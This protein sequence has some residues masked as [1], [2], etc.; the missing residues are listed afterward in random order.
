MIITRTPLRMSFVGG[1]SDISDFYRQHG[2]AVLSST[3]DQYVYINVHK[4]FS[5]QVRLAYSKVEEEENFSRIEHPLVRGAAMLTGIK[6][7]LE[8]T[9][10]ADIPSKGSGLGSSSSFAVGLL[11]ALTAY[12]GSDISKRL[13]AEQACKLEIELCEQPIGKQD[14]FAASFGGFNI[15]KFAKNDKV[16]VEKLSVTDEARFTLHQHMMVFYTGKTRSASL[17]LADQKRAMAKDKTV[18]KMLEMVELV[19]TFKECLL[20]C[21]AKGSGE[22]LDINWQ[23]KKSLS[24]SISSSGIDEVYEIARKAGAYGG[25]LLGAGGSGFLLFLVPPAKQH[26]VSLALAKLQRVYW[27]FDTVGSTIIYRK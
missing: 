9:S 18:S 21:D 4:S 6:D 2:G 5:G 16:T 17:I 26:S 10:I 25:K 24:G 1:G 22:L 11:H 3:I 23:L 13:L 8:I 14:Q 27:N 20:N 7:G 19:P 12:N 15:I